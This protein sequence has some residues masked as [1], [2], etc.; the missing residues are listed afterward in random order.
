MPREDLALAIE[1]GVVAIFA[2]QHMR[3]QSWARHSLGDGTLRR[4]SLVDRPAGTATVFGTPDAQNPQPCR[5]EVERLADRLADDMERIAA[6]GTDASINI[7]RH[8][9]ARQMLGKSLPA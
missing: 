1:R 5:H 6:A 7:D 3:Q 8:V 2:H 4:S 9:F